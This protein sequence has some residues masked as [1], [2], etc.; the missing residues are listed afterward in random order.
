M[1][2]LQQAQRGI[3]KNTSLLHTIV[4]PHCRGSSCIVVLEEPGMNLRLSLNILCRPGAGFL[5]SP[6]R[7]QAE[8]RSV[9][10]SDEP[11]GMNFN[12][13]QANG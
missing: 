1:C 12:P 9:P 6:V 7:M 13:S 3:H 8:C 11:S 10:W 4:Q 5:A 2:L